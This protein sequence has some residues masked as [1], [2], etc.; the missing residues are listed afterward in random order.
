MILM[1]NNKMEQ[2]KNNLESQGFSQ[3]FIKKALQDFN[4][5]EEEKEAE[6]FDS[7]EEVIDYYAKKFSFSWN[8]KKT[9]NDLKELR[10]DLYLLCKKDSNDFIDFNLYFENIEMFEIYVLYTLY[11]EFYPQEEEEEIA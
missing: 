10:E 4:E 6:D 9:E 2:F 3:D 8:M 1:K 11:F 5:L 7:V